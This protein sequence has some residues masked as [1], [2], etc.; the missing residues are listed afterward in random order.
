M[1]LHTRRCQLKINQISCVT[2]VAE[3]EEEEQEEN[4]SPLLLRLVSSL[5][6]SGAAEPDARAR[7]LVSMIAYYVTGRPTTINN[8][9]QSTLV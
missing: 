1:L 8:R 5:K 2:Q 9:L 3:L 4:F 6:K 7:A